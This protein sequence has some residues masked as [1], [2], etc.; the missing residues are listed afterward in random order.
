MEEAKKGC[1]RTRRAKPVGKRQKG[2]KKYQEV[3]SSLRPK[4]VT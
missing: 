1:E 2:E 4:Y 3:S